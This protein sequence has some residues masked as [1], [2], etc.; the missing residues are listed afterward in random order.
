MK[1]EIIRHLHKNFDEYAKRA[2]GGL[3][4]WFARDLQK[5][6]GYDQWRNFEKVI[7]KAKVAAVTAGLDVLDHF[8]D[9]SKMIIAG[10]GAEREVNDTALTRHAC[11]LR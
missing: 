4:F 8:A 5:L 1:K 2:S 9:A 10:K 7:D 11:Y 6:L 3:E